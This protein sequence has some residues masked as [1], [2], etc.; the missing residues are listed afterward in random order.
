MSLQT[1][2]H[3]LLEPHCP[4]CR[5]ELREKREESKVCESCE[6]LTRQLEIANHNNE[7]LLERLLKEPTTEVT[8]SL[9]ATYVP[10]KQV[11]WAVRRQMLETED[12]R[13]AQFMRNAI[14]PDVAKPSNVKDLE[15]ELGVEEDGYQDSETE[16]KDAA[17]QG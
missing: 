1:F 2:F 13:K 9:P 3:H 5:A 16:N 11:P 6:T 15:K 17:H 7:L 10:P 4:D 8:T 14:K 12:R